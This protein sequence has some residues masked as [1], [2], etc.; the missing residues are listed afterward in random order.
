MHRRWTSAKHIIS[1]IIAGRS[2][3]ISSY[4]HH[5]WPARCPQEHQ[6]T[7]LVPWINPKGHSVPSLPPSPPPGSLPLRVCFPFSS[8]QLFLTLTL[9]SIHPVPSSFSSKGYRFFITFLELFQYLHMQIQT[10]VSLFYFS[11]THRQTPT[12]P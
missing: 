2:W 12:P 6:L 5:P 7:G 11:L 9:V 1:I 4:G 10:S 3:T 8:Q